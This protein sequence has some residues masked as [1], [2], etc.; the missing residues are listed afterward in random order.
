MNSLEKKFK[1]RLKKNEL[2]KNHTTF[3]IGGPAKYFLEAKSGEELV[4]AVGLAKDDGLDYAVIGK[5][6][7][8]LVSDQGYNGLI[9]K[10]SN[11]GHRKLDDARLLVD[12]GLD[13][14]KLSQ[15]AMENGLT[16][17][18]WAMDVPG[19]VGGAI[20]MN[21]GCFGQEMKDYVTKVK[22][23]NSRALDIKKSQNSN[24]SNIA[25]INSNNKFNKLIKGINNKQCKF[26]YRES[27]FKQ[28]PE[29]IILEAELKL[30]KGDKKDIKQKIKEQL[31]QR[32]QKIPGKPSAGSIFKKYEILKGEKLNEKLERILQKE[33]P[34]FI[35]NN[36]IPA[37]WLI[38]EA[39]LKGKIVGGAQISE[40]H[41]NFIVNLGKATAE[42]IVIL[43]A[44][45]KQKVRN[46]LGIQL[47]EEVMYLGF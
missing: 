22:Y 16:G 44:I 9:I 32:S 18:E 38:E 14:K 25:Q 13:L 10:M 17:V 28:H 4:E 12:A 7:N 8:I 6:S 29:W 46:E 37:G 20:T 24:I 33:H 42:Q 11:V 1:T 40:K 2:M 41:A 34:E 31:S 47:Q 30:K 45:I 19:T 5:G 43:I 15:F 3:R 36:Y 27:I 26:G 21:A 23:L 35:K 39:G